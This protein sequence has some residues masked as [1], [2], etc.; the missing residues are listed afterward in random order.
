MTVEYATENGSATAPADYQATNGTVT[1][2]PGQIFRDVHGADRERQPRRDRRDVPGQSLGSAE[3]DDSGRPGSR[4]RS[5]TTTR[6]PT[7]AV[8]DVTVLEGDSGTVAATFTVSLNVAERPFGDRQLRHRQRDGGRAWRL[9]RR[10]TARS[11]SRPARRR[12]RSPCLVNGDLLDEANETFFVDLSSP[13]N[14]T[15]L[16][17]QGIV[18]DHGRRRDAG[19]LDQ[20]RDCHGRQLGNDQRDLHGHAR[21]DERPD[22]DRSVRDRRRDGRRILGLHGGWEHTHVRAR[23]I[24]EDDRGA[25]TRR[26]GD[27]GERDLPR[28]PLER[29][30]CGT[31]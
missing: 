2:N 5:P 6:L 14:A 30:E 25:G 11:C 3:R 29:H 1:F 8:D 17:H 23:R 28:Q 9:R 7:L 31:H 4:A 20:R 15:F 21:T 16:D 27:R 22:R 19:A 10:R 18:H 24:D 26:H 13:T 12:S